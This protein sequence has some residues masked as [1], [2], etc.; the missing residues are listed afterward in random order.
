MSTASQPPKAKWTRL[1]ERV[2]EVDIRF[3]HAGR[4]AAAPDLFV[5]DL[6][7]QLVMLAGLVLRLATEMR[8]AEMEGSALT[9]P[10]QALHPLSR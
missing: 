10:C 3:D 5:S 9:V 4:M 7:G 1:S 6:A 8:D 2:R